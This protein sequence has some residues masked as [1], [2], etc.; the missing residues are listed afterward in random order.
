MGL[1]LRQGR[2]EIH[3]CTSRKQKTRMPC[4]TGH[5]GTKSGDS[6]VPPHLSHPGTALSSSLQERDLRPIPRALITVAS[7]ACLLGGF[8]FGLRLTGPFTCPLPASFPPAG[9]SLKA[10]WQATSPDH[11]PFMVGPRIQVG[12]GGVNIV[13]TC[14]HRLVPDHRRLIV[15]DGPEPRMEPS[16]RSV[17][18]L[19]KGR[20]NSVPR[21]D[22]ASGSECG[23]CPRS[24]THILG[25]QR[26]SFSPGIGACMVR[27][28]KI[29]FLETGSA[30]AFRSSVPGLFHEQPD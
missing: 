10:D 1:D 7:P 3:R 14:R 13:R 29:V 15:G 28:D 24:V 4:S 23:I 17:G 21:V 25:P 16:R 5:P 26:A 6:A 22:G 30:K 19:P 11:S 12:S 27:D 8:P 9:S 18:P 20:S 2:N